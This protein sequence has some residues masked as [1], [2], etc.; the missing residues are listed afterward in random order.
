MAQACDR[1][2]LKKTRCDGKRPQCSQ[3]AA[4][5]FE[6]KV[7]DR[8]SRRAFPRGYTETLEERVRELEAENRR[9]L[10]LLDLRDE[11]MEL[12]SKVDNGDSNSINQQKQGH[13]QPLSSSNLSLLNKGHDQNGKNGLPLVTEYIDHD[14]KHVHSGPGCCANYPHSVHERPVSIAGSVDLDNGDLTDDEA[15]SFHDF[16]EHGS[17]H[18]PNNP[19]NVSFEQSQAPGLAA[20]MA[21]ARMNSSNSKRTQ[22]A[23]LVAMAIPRSTEETL[24]IP[25]LLSKIGEFHGLDSKACFATSGAIAALKEI[26][27]VNTKTIQ[28]RNNIINFTNINFKKISAPESN[29]FFNHLKLPPKF[30]LDQLMTIYFQEWGMIIPILDKNDFL[31]QYVQFAK[32]FEN[33]FN[34]NGMVFKER[35]GAIMILIVQL[36]LLC[37]KNHNSGSPLSSNSEI[38]GGGGQDNSDKDQILYYDYLIHQLIDSSIAS[39]CSIQSLQILSLA[40]FYCLNTGDVITS[41]GLRGRVITMAQQLR[42]H[43][44]PSAVLGNNGSTVSKFQQAE[45]RILFWCIYT[46]DTF[47]SL[48]LGVPRLLKDYEIECALPFGNDNLDDDNNINI[49]IVNNNQVSLV[50]KVCNLSLAIMR[51]SKVLGN[52]LDSIFKRHSHSSSD[53]FQ[54]LT[55]IHES[56]LDNWRRDLPSNLKFELD[57]N[58]LLKDSKKLTNDKQLLLVLLYYS[59]KILI[60]L[61]VIASEVDKSRGSAS[62]IVIQQCTIAILNILSDL[63]SKK[64]YYIPIPMNISRT[65]SRLALLS[66]KGSLEYTRGGALFQESKQILQSIIN[67]LKDENINEIP[68]NLSKNCVVLIENA[69]E[70]IISSPNTKDNNTP[71]RKATPDLALKKKNS[72]LKQV[73]TQRA[74]AFSHSGPSHQTEIKT[75]SSEQLSNMLSQLDNIPPISYDSSTAARRVPVNRPRSVSVSHSQQQQQQQ[76]IPSPK[77]QQ[78]TQ[79]KP[80]APSSNSGDSVNSLEDQQSMEYDFGADGSLGLAPWLDFDLNGFDFGGYNVSVSGELT[81]SEAQQQQQRQFQQQYQFNDNMQVKLEPQ[82]TGDSTTSGTTTTPQQQQQRSSS[83]FDWQNSMGM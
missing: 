59:A 24:F 14:P 81:P 44:C 31:Q 47:A 27:K 26:P 79:F 64:T 33:K 5:G 1:C 30:H 82:L 83:L 76:F 70:A 15:L 32:S 71:T 61:P 36:A 67:E 74:R 54:E 68:G 13:Q 34:D 78:Q 19:N 66:A 57:V 49:L 42:L 21:I 77:D 40:L 22:L 28:E 69:I 62:Y 63:Y 53:N 35:F 9:L 12:Y 48:Q 8:L 16:S 10:A 58:G 46:L 73:E 2:R 20:A 29:L 6:C 45:R 50:G 80:I 51:F 52:V 11:Q 18:N 17:F 7:S 3:C 60:H 43:R 56:L 55:L 25:S 38:N 4:V 37:Q 75:E 23:T 39:T 72:P 41:Y 65:K